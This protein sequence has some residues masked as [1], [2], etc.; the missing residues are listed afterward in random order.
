[1]ATARELGAI[2]PQDP[3]IAYRA[4][5]YIGLS[6]FFELD[7]HGG[8]WKLAG[9]TADVD[10]AGNCASQIRHDRAQLCADAGF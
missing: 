2:S 10:L 3:T 6:L 7:A 8:K 5:G 4:S 9:R 1:V